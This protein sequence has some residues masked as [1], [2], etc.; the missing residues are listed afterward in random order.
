[1]VFCSSGGTVYGRSQD[2]AIDEN[3]PLRPINAYGA[4]KLAAEIYTDL[5]RR[6]H[7]LDVRVARVANPYGLGQFPGRKQGALSL[8]A[9]QAMAGSVIE[10][11]GDGSVIRDYLHIDDVVSALA[12]LADT[13]GENLGPT[14][15]FNIASGQGT[16]LNELVH[17]ISELLEVSISVL[18]NSGRSI[19]VPRNVL[20]I[21]RANRILKWRPMLNMRDGVA[22]LIEELRQVEGY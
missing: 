7:G 3:H 17:L 2:V 11:W 18:Y 19:D 1:V 21:E 8:F 20:S 16:S 14:S 4:G 10:I 13:P 22:K 9:A 15:V 6:V 5:Y 12:S